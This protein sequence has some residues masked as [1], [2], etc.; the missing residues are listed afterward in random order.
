MLTHLD[1]QG[2]KILREVS[3]T[4]E[5]LTVFVGPNGCG[6][7][8]VLETIAMV[9]DFVE[10]GTESAHEYSFEEL[11]S[12]GWSAD[13]TLSVDLL[14]KLGPADRELVDGLLESGAIERVDEEATRAFA[15]QVLN[16]EEML[17]WF[18]MARSLQED[19]LLV[20]V[21][22]ENDPYSPWRVVERSSWKFSS[23]P[24]ESALFR[25]RFGHARRLRLDPR[26]LA[27]PSY[28][29]AV[30]PRLASD[31][32]GLAEVLSW[33]QGEHYERFEGVQAQLRELVPELER[34]R[35]R[36][37]TVTVEEL[38]VEPR[39]FIGSQ[40]VFDFRHAMGISAKHASKST[41]LLLGL[42]TAVAMGG[43]STLLLD[44]IDQALHP[45][46][47]RQLL[48][49]LRNVAA[50]GIQVIAASSSPHVALHLEPDE[51][52]VMATSEDGG[53][54]VGTI[55]DGPDFERWRAHMA[56][57][58]PWAVPGDES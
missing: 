42:L 2:Y 31:G 12:G 26:R 25:S 46:T 13:S 35:I 48:G 1:I 18:K 27:E 5:P 39:E 55:T 47:Q 41:L 34:V 56:M 29:S 16:E 23:R 43:V 52:R 8:S 7:T 6:K 3:T 20:R 50:Q 36:R 54:M 40:V 38:A 19:E 9:R 33:L 49:F 30:V 53:A 4:L 10:Q 28:S 24:T 44:D 22:H 11:A 57:P 32:S 37:A 51:V 21:H 58:E 14:A 17:T 45:R 15:R